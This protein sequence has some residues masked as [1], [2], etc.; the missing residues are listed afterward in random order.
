[1]KFIKILLWEY[2]KEHTE[3]AW[4]NYDEA[5]V[6][7]VNNKSWLEPSTRRT[8]EDLSNYK[9]I[10]YNYF[11]YN[12]YRVNVGSIWLFKWEVGLV[13]PAYVVFSLDETQI[14]P[15]L[16]IAYLRSS[17]GISKINKHTYWWVRKSLSFGNLSKIELN[18]ASIEEQKKLMDAL[19]EKIND[20]ELLKNLNESSFEL[21]KK[22]K[23]SILQDA[24]QWKLVLQDPS[25][26]PASI[27]IEKIQAEKAK[28]IAEW[29]LKKQKPLAPIQPEEIPYELPKGWEW[30]RLGE[31]LKYIQRWPSAKYSEKSNI[32]IINQKC[33]Q[34]RGLELDHI[35]YYSTEL[36]E[37]LNED[38]Y[39]WKDDILLNSTWTGT[40]GRCILLDELPLKSYIADSHVTV[41]RSFI[42]QK[43]I[44]TF[45]SSQ[46][47]QDFL[48]N[49][50]VF[51]TTNQIELSSSTIQNFC[52]P[53]PPLQEQKRIVEKID[54]LMK[55][56]ESLDE[57]I[58]QAKDRS[59]KLMESVLQGVFNW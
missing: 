4:L 42:S 49:G 2:I 59:K 21:S 18:I 24:I 1:M 12:P 51:G 17:T 14:I 27:L 30:V 58:R 36:I 25:D 45:L 10:K 57:Q 28:L 40:I 32:G 23:S 22:L 34:W 55:S 16:L 52:F 15:D 53:L 5:Q 43:Y 35:K 8:S 39:L 20:F 9:I 47:I 37:R 11:A 46:G 3:R 19:K 13:S 44:L 56:C 6:Y 26:E 33:I 7:W 54:E 31:I 48:N 50:W 38:R 29:K 41:L